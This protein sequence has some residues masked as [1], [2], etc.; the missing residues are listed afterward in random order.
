MEQKI[1]N[2]I[3]DTFNPEVILLGG[4]RAKGR[5]KKDSDWD[6]FLLKPTKGKGGLVEYAGELLEITFKSWPEKNKPLTIPSGPL[7][8]VKILFDNSNGNLQL[9]LDQTEEAFKKGPMVL[10]K[11]S[12]LE[13]FEKLISWQRKIKKYQDH[14]MVEFFYA[15]IF[16]EF[17]I[18]AWFELQNKWSVSPAE[19]ISYI[20]DNDKRFFELLNNFTKYNSTKRLEFTE[21]IMEKLN[22]LTS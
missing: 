16:Y 5:E 19:A 14:P 11:N 2:Y 13:R 8:P 22:S 9:L 3:K 17:A 20:K 1:I 10:Y 7:L 18:R 4:S 6:L 15:G 21:K 12:V